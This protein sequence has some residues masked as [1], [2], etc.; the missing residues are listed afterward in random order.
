MLKNAATK[1]M[2]LRI[3]GYY[4]GKYLYSTTNL[5]LLLSHKD[6]GVVAQNEMVALAA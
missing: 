4:Q 6:H 2:R 1:K 3:V 5:G